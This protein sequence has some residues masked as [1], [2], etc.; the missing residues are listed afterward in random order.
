ML[1]RPEVTL[2]LQF[3]ASA[4]QQLSEDSTLNFYN[5]M[6]LYA[7]CQSADA[8]HK[9]PQSMEKLAFHSKALALQVQQQRLHCIWRKQKLLQECSQVPQSLRHGLRR[10][11]QHY[12]CAL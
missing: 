12:I 8:L 7:D 2:F 10:H 3:L 4:V 6:A 5:V 11:M 9:L 1:C